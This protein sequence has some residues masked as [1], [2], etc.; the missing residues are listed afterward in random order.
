L[1]IF[2]EIVRNSLTVEQPRLGHTLDFVVDQLWADSAEARQLPDEPGKHKEV[3]APP[4][5]N[6][7]TPLSVKKTTFGSA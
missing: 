5:Q 1:Q 4:G 2:S 6:V 3:F 7:T